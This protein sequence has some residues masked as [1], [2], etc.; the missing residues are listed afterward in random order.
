MAGAPA[1]RQA[2][3]VARALTSPAPLRPRLTCL[4]GGGP[5][6]P[7]SVLRCAG[8]HVAR[9]TPAAPHVLD[10]W[11]P[12]HPA[13]RPTLRRP[14]VARSTPAAPHCLTGGGPSTPVVRARI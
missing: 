10:W 7:P 1:P 12:R 14:H 11:G 13:K 2:S 8:A 5:G 6:T 9:S 4:S 3:Y